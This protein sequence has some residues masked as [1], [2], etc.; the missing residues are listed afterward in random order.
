MKTILVV[1]ILF[2]LLKAFP[3]NN[4]NRISPSNGITIEADLGYYKAFAPSQIQEFM[5]NE[6]LDLVWGGGWFGDPGSSAP[7]IDDG[8]PFMASFMIGYLFKDDYEPGIWVNFN[9]NFTVNG[10]YQGKYGIYVSCKAYLVGA[11]F[12]YHLHM[13]E[14]SA[15]PA[16]QMVTTGTGDNDSM[17]ENKQTIAGLFGGV[18]LEVPK[19]PSLA[20][21]ILGAKYQYFFSNIKIGPY[22]LKEY[23]INGEPVE[24]TLPSFEANADSFMIFAGVRFNLRIKK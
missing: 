22:Q 1:S 20:D 3:Q 2:C 6:G 13:F 18:N 4:E 14:F 17:D 23:D 7:D 24:Y 5:Q 12:R 15:G 10:E 9:D 11:Y 21:F 8:N 19:R 16:L